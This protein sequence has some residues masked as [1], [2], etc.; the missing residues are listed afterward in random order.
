MLTDLKRC[1]MVSEEG[2]RKVSEY[3]RKLSDDVGMIS[4]GLRSVLK[5]LKMVS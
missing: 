3:F 2:L 4:D 1:N 5:E